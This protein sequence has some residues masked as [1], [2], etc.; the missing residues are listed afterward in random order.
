VRR[1]AERTV[2][3]VERSQSEIRSLLTK[4]GANGFMF[5][6]Q[7]D[8]ALVGFV[9]RNRQIRFVLPMAKA[10]ARGGESERTAAAETR[11]RWRA[12]LLVLKAK[13]EA[14][15][16]GIVEFDRE[17]LAHIVTDGGI[18]IGDRVVP[19]IQAAIESGRV[20]NLLGDGS[21]A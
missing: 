12:L 11:R 21:G 9:M 19:H 1:Y 6:E 5:G 7:E 17:F 20:P 2:V 13:L 14:V 10:K 8:R 18:T 4:Y 15:A 16:S 3:P